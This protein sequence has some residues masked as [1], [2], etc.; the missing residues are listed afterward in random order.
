MRTY[1]RRA[2]PALAALVST[3]LVLGCTAESEQPDQPESGEHTEQPVEQSTASDVQIP[4]GALGEQVSWLLQLLAADSGPDPEAAQERFTE[5]FLGAVGGDLE[6]VFDELR[7]TGPFTVDYLE[8]HGAAAEVGLTDGSGQPLLME[9]VLEED[10][11]IAGLLF[12][13]DEIRQREVAESWDE[14]QEEVAGVATNAVLAAYRV[15]DG[16]CTGPEHE[17]MPTGSVFKLFVLGAVAQAVAD[18]DLAWDETVTVTDEVRSLPSGELQE[19]PEGTEVT[20]ADAAAGMIQISDNTATDMLIDAVGRQAIEEALPDLGASEPQLLRPF[21]TTRELFL[22]GW[23]APEVLDQWEGADPET[24]REL[25]TQL[26]EDLDAVPPEAVTTPVWTEGADWLIPAQDLCEVH[27]RLADL[28]PEVRDILGQNPGIALDED[29]WEYAGFKG[30]SAPGVTAGAWYLE[31]A[32]GQPVV[33]V[34]Q[35]ADPAQPIDPR[36]FAALAENAAA[37]LAED[38]ID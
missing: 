19:A 21:L 5:G 23:G 36:L 20:I 4:D 12:S 31:P 26:P 6:A 32:D 13:P 17:P 22:L 7:A 9:V 27:T 35:L 8:D 2:L 33:L 10:D 25:L 28:G 30:G 34:L 29:A 11:R 24:R 15:Q 3:L 38:A 16:V 14:L 18:G 1:R 37:L